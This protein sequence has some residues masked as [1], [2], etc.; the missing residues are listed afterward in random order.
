LV[1]WEIAWKN[2][3][4]IDVKSTKSEAYTCALASNMRNPKEP[5]LSVVATT[6]AIEGKL[7]V[8]AEE[9]TVK[10][11]GLPAAFIAVIVIYLNILQKLLRPS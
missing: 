8:N 11:F 6:I 2:A 7:L 1:L 3:P 10:E 5:I 4:R 9:D